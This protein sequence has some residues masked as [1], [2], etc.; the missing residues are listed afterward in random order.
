LLA[1]SVGFTLEQFYKVLV[2]I[3]ENVE[4]RA[5]GLFIVEHRQ[6]VMGIGELQQL[7]ASHGEF[8]IGLVG[9]V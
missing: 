6:M 5:L 8:S 2:V 9:A 3:V 1:E 7:V 4:H